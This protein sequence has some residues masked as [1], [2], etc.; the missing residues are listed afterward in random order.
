MMEE[1]EGRVKGLGER[2]LALEGYVQGT[3]GFGG[4]TLTEVLSDHSWEENKGV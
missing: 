4:L 2:E 1:R 3:L